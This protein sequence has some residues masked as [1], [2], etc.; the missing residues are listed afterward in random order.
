MLNIIQYSTLEP[1]CASIEMTNVG[2]FVFYFI[3]LYNVKPF[4]TQVS[5]LFT[6]LTVDFPL[7]IDVL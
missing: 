3:F 1:F 6:K 7:F 4:L 5:S 2:L